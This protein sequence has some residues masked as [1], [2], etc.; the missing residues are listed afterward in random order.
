MR[1]LWALIEKDLRLFFADRRGAL[2]TIATPVVLGVLLGM[3]FAPRSK[4]RRIELLVV[5]QD[6]SA[7]VQQFVA[8]IDQEQSLHVRRVGEGEA[9]RLLSHGKSSVALLIPRGAGAGLDAAALFSARPRQTVTLLGDPSRPI[10]REIVA[11]LLQKVMVAELAKRLGEAEQLQRLFGQLNRELKQDSATNL[12]TVAAL[13]SFFSAGNRLA[14]TIKSNP[15]PSPKQRVALRPPLRIVSQSVTANTA[16]KYNSYAHNFS[17]M[18]C[19]FLMF[20]GLHAAKAL[21]A[22]RQSG[23]L[24]RLRAAP[25]PRWTILCATGISTTLIACLISLLL[26][27]VAIIGFGVRINGSAW[28]FGLVLFAQALFIGGFSLLLAGFGRSDAQIANIGTF[29]ILVLSFTGGATLPSFL[30]PRWLQQIALLFPTSWAT[31]GL[32]AM[33]WR[34]LPLGEALLSS[35]VLLGFAGVSA[36]LGIWKFRW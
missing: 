24:L 7:V 1:A 19:M 4:A 3:L 31:H 8:A 23:T 25:I 35:A 12:L 14:T 17:G 20:F 32:A 10:E 26:Y 36:A 18:L 33:T 11:G 5:D 6:R 29:A 13:R 16:G 22:E 30:M 2:L 21:L 9:R 34:A 27:L 28:G 15:S